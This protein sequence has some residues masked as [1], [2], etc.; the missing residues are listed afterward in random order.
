MKWFMLVLITL[1]TIVTCV[2]V[3][4]IRDVYAAEPS[5]IEQLIVRAL[6]TQRRD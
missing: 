3:Q 4:A 2:N 6:E 5:P 1:A